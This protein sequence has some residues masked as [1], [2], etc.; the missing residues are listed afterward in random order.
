[1]TVAY[2]KNGKPRL[3][4]D[5]RHINEKLHKFKFKYEDMQVARKMLEKGA[6]VFGFD[7]RGAYNHIDIFAE[8][9]T[10]LGFSWKY[11]GVEHYY[12]YNSL[13][14]GLASAGHIFT[15]VVR[16][17]IAYLR[18]KGHI[19][20]TFLDDGLGGSKSYEKALMSSEFVRH[21]L[22][23]LGF[24]LSDEKCQWVP[25][26]TITWLGYFLNMGSG[27]FYIT[28]DRIKRIQMA[29]H[30]FLTQL[31]NQDLSIV[32]AKFAASI[33]GQIISTQLVLGK[34]VRLKTRE[35]YKCIDSRLSWESPVFISE[36]AVEELLFWLQNISLLNEKGQDL[37]ESFIVEVSMFCDASSEGYGGYLEFESHYTSEGKRSIINES[38]TC[39]KD[40]LDVGR[41][42]KPHVF[43]DRCLDIHGKTCKDEL[44]GDRSG[45]V[46]RIV[47]PETESLFPKVSSER[48]QNS[49]VRSQEEDLRFPPE[50][51]YKRDQT[52][53]V[54][55][56][57]VDSGFPPEVGSKRDQ[58]LHVRSPEVDLRFSPEVGS[59]RDKNFCMRSPE[60][61]LRFP[62]EVGS[63]RD[64]MSQVRSPEVDLR[65]PPEVGSKRDQT[66]QV[67]SPEVDLRFSPEVGLD[68]DESFC[69]RSPEVDLRF[70]LEVGS[71][72]DQTSQVSFPEVDWRF[73]P[74][75]GLDRNKS[76]CVRS[77]EV[78]LRFS[79]EVGSY[80]DKNSSLRSPE[81]DMRISLEL[82]KGKDQANKS[83]TFGYGSEPNIKGFDKTITNEVLGSWNN[84]EKGKSSTWREAEAVRRV[85]KS[86]LDQIRGRNVKVYS[87]NKNVQSVLNV[88]SRK[89]DLQNVANDVYGICQSNDISMSIQWIPREL[90]ER[91]DYLSRCRDSDDWSVQEWVFKY[92]DEKWG[93]H[94]IDRFAS[95]YNTQCT[96]FNSRW[97]VPGTLAVDALGQFWGKPEVNWAVPPP[98]LIP[99][100]LKKIEKENAICTLIVP[101]WPSAPFYPALQSDSVKSHIV[102]TFVLPRIN[103]IKKGLG[104]NGFFVKEPLSFNML[105]LKFVFTSC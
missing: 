41:S 86:S 38:R 15:K 37:S 88:G 77:P 16:V 49:H 87:D 71:Q 104:N 90:N 42:D 82:E 74:E 95:F 39:S 18:S 79:L 72:R 70:P 58:T 43:S 48:D 84:E 17:V 50:T 26:L 32:S 69:V 103:V 59:V 99:Q 67:R 100:I 94:T 53:Q 102:D 81:V 6:Y 73:S 19:V 20:I 10:F 78:D 80:R 34:I 66:S 35:L 51:G 13:P 83:M 5:C 30:S 56:L 21:T 98:R 40:S 89:E 27:K 25:A 23:E 61:D 105:A 75:V 62:P 47:F 93:P 7:I 29:L 2:N 57:E 44:S 28:K 64:Q 63:K 92:L 54:R 91:S 24:L 65:F 36:K 46:H 3:V 1:M 85:L 60:V 11:D 33:A 12:M 31:Q 101:E 76:F 9:R 52:S 22:L 8:H 55:A 14:F 97:W 68:K 45:I 4:L 96:R